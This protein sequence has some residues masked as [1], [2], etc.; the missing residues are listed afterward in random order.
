MEKMDNDILLLYPSCGEKKEMK[1]KNFGGYASIDEYLVA[2]T[3]RL[4]ERE[5]TFATLFE[6]MFSEEENTFA[7][8]SDGFRV[9]KVT[10]GEGK[11][12][13]LQAAK[14]IETRLGKGN[15]E[16]VGFTATAA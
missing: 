4:E 7:E 11:I 14:A 1:N 6:F 8:L 5:K 12:L 16:L 10:Y 3:L 15:G 13:C 9:M 2:K